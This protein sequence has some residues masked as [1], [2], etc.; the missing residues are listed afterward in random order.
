[1]AALHSL[2]SSRT[3]R[4][5]LKFH[6]GYIIATRAAPSNYRLSRRRRRGFARVRALTTAGWHAAAA[7]GPRWIRRMVAVS[8]VV[9]GFVLS[10]AVL[11]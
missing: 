10:P 9:L 4:S 1:M 8:T 11:S 7:A 5:S 6:L 2:V 3:Y